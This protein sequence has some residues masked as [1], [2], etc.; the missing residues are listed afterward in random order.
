[1]IGIARHTDYGA[2][3]VLHLAC[4]EPGTRVTVAEIAEKRLR[5]WVIDAEAV[6]KA[7]GLGDP[8]RDD[9]HSGKNRTGGSPIQSG[10]SR[11]RE[12]SRF[13]RFATAGTFE[14]SVICGR[15]ATTK[16]TS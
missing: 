3:V 12:P 11:K 2:R 16:P 6:A 14:P 10:P 7:A 1:M 8:A 5:T 4:L 9:G 13:Y 15:S